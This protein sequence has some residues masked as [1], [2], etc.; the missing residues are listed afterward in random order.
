MRKQKEALVKKFDNW[1]KQIETLEYSRE[2]FN[3]AAPLRADFPSLKTPDALH[4]ATAT[5]H[6]CDEFWTNDDRLDK[7]A[8][9]L[10][11]NML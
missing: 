8:P 3:L 1:F 5:F 2:I 6:N 9:D 4:L 11:K 10:V 7:I